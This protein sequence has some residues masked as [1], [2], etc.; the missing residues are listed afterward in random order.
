MTHPDDRHQEDFERPFFADRQRL[1]AAN[2]LHPSASIGGISVGNYRKA[3][4]TLEVSAPNDS[5][6]VYYVPVMLTDIPPQHAWRNGRHRLNPARPPAS[7]CS[8]DLR[9]RWETELCFAFHTLSFYVPQAAFDEVTEELGQAPVDRLSC[10]PSVVTI[11][12]IIH[13]L[14]LAL[15]AIIEAGDQLPSLLADHMLSAVRLQLA[16]RHGGLRVPHLRSASLSA[17]QISA[18]KALMLDEPGRDVRLAELAAMCD[19]PLRSFERAF[20][21]TFG[22]S[23]HRWRLEAKVQRARKMVELTDRPLAEIA[24]TCGFSDQSHLTRVFVRAVGMPPGA[25]RHDRRT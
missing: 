3:T 19:L 6:P 2:Y 15:V 13:H 22:S 9:E 14:S 7:L 16:V 17:T 11:D 1:D 25:Y 23:P 10:V 8:F 4:P 24:S 12:P 5:L 18:L 20:R 21:K